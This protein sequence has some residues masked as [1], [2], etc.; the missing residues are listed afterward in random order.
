M[1]SCNPVFI[2]LGQKLGVETYFKYL[3]KFGLLAKTGVSLPRRG[4]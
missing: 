1:N 3:N 4:K 2:G